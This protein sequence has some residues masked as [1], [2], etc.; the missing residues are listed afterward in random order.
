MGVSK[1]F[2]AITLLILA[3][4][5]PNTAFAAPLEDDKVVFGGTFSLSE[6]E[7]LDG[8][9]LV[10]GGDVEIYEGARIKGNVAIVGGTIWIDG[11]VD[12]DVTQV[13]GSLALGSN[14]HVFGDIINNGGSVDR[15]EGS[16]IDGDVRSGVPQVE[17]RRDRSGNLGS[18]ILDSLWNLFVVFAF[19]AMTVV[20]AMLWQT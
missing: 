17:I 12:G 19:A 14:S 7:I 1:K 4:L 9:L 16:Q 6:G 3:L 8:D 5:I 10:F 13:G 15:E 20:I 2:V 11:R 18:F